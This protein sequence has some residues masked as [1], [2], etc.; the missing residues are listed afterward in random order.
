MEKKRSRSATSAVEGIIGGKMCLQSAT[1]VRKGHYDGKEA[2]SE[3]YIGDG[4]KYWWKEVSPERYIIRG[5]T[6]LGA[7]F[8]SFPFMCG[9]CYLTWG[10]FRLFPT[11]V[12]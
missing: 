7:T 6:S 1:L 2:L 10:Y 8:A 4:R 12:R 3:H 9:N 11:Y 5:R